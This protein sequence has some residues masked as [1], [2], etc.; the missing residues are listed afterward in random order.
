MRAQAAKRGSPFLNTE[1]AAAWLK[2]SAKL[3][4]R[5]RRRAEGPHFRRHGRVVRYHI[6]DLTAW[7]DASGQHGE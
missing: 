4:K 6:D 1:Q 3:L 2:V 7:S 5:M